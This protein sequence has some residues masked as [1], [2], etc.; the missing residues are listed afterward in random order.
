VILTRRNLQQLARKRLREA[1]LLLQA[2]EYDGAYY[3]AGLGIECAL[4][5]CIAR[6]TR[7]HDFPSKQVVIE[8]YSHELTR[9][10]KVA[11]LEN[12]FNQESNAHAAFA[13]NWNVV[14]DWRVESRYTTVA[15]QTA[16]DMYSA[17]VSRSHG[18]MPWIR[19]NW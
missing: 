4:K 8:S 5:A 19:R 11:G 17:V 15:P 1:R 13:N 6:G 2:Q 18:V 9:L 12:T 14:K 7:R 10:M 3:L 16:R